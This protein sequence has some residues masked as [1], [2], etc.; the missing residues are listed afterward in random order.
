MRRIPVLA[1]A[2]AAFLLGTTTPAH[3]QSLGDRLKRRAKEAAER[4]VEQRVDQRA[5]EA[6]DAAL[7]KGENTVKCAATDKK[8]IDNAKKAGKQVVTDDNAGATG[9]AN[10]APTS[11]GG[12]AKAKSVNT[13][14]DFTP[15]TR[16]LFA[17]DFK[18]DEIGD[19]PRRLELKAGNMEVADVGGTRYLRITSSQA[20]VDIP[21]LE[22][23]PDMFTMEFDL[24]PV[25]GY[26][27][28]MY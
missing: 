25:S 9:A 24:L 7:D 23:L 21:L 22:V 13:G 28:Y 15:G 19:F 6:T 26:E 3:S 11:G 14:K 20:K 5:G 27:Q 1:G 17:T 2:A 4:K 16:V 10:V 18:N 8:C 12:A